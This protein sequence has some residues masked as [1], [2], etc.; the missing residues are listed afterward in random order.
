M[1]YK[2]GDLEEHFFSCQGELA[3]HS[4]YFQNARHCFSKWGF[5]LEKKTKKKKSFF[6]PVESWMTKY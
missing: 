6:S 4:T 2:G 1:R 5:S 3:V